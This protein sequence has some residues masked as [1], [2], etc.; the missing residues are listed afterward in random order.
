MQRLHKDTRFVADTTQLP[1]MLAKY[2]LREGD[3]VITMGAGD[4]YKL[5]ELLLHS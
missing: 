3:V 5:H 2:W 4:V 1:D